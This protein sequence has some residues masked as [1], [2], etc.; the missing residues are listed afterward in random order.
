V[1]K[2]AEKG[3]AT[4]TSEQSCKQANNKEENFTTFY[5]LLGNTAYQ[6]NKKEKDF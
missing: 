6:I 2:E 5:L 4:Q 1:E 3:G